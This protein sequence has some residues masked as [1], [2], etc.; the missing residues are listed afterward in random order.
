M[1]SGS[2]DDRAVNEPVQMKARRLRLDLWV[3]V[4]AD[5]ELPPERIVADGIVE[6]LGDAWFTVDDGDAH[7][8]S[9]KWRARYVGDP[10]IIAGRE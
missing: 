2:S 7:A 8:V 3:Y 9:T 6:G 10:E 5:E 1:S 4:A